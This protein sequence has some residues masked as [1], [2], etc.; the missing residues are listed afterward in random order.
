MKKVVF[1]LWLVCMSLGLLGNV[2]MSLIKF[3]EETGFGK[4]HSVVDFEVTDW[5]LAVCYHVLILSK[6]A[7]HMCSCCRKSC[8]CGACISVEKGNTGIPM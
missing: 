4:I 5:E 3:L 6:N 8:Y 2:W 7:V 1:L